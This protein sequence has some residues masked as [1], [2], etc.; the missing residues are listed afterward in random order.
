MN[1]RKF[2]QAAFSNLGALALGARLPFAGAGDQGRLQREYGAGQLDGLPAHAG[3]AREISLVAEPAQ[4]E[5][6]TRGVFEKWLY[7]GQF[8]GPEIRVKEG[9]RLRVTVKNSLPEATTVHW[10]GLPVQ[11][12]M[13]GVPDVTQPP[14]SPDDTFVYEFD[15]TPSGSYMYHSHFGLQPDRGLVGPLIVEEKKAHIDYDREYTLCLTDFLSGAP[16][17]LGS[18]MSGG[19]GMRST[20]VPPYIG[21]LINGRPPE[22]PA[23]F[24]VKTGERV[25][26]R[27]INPS[28]ATTYRFAIG[29]HPLTATHT[30]GRPVEP[31]RVEALYI[32]P[33]ERYDVLVD[34]RNPGAW[35]IAA[36]PDNDLPPARAVLR[37]TDSNESRPREGALPEGLT[38]GR[39]LQLGDLRGIGLPETRKPNRTF[40]LT[41]S[42]AMK[43][44]E[45]MISPEWTINGQAYP[46]AAPLDIH[47]GETVR[48][49]MVN[50]S[51]MPHP[52]HLHGHF[53]R[54]GN[55][56]KDTVIVWTHTGRVEFDF[57]A[58]NP[59]TWFFH[60]HNLYHM[61]AGMARLLRYQSTVQ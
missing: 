51:A 56:M 34:A 36:A 45:G 6:A 61:E 33:G 42:G 40:N 28:G 8:P 48:V 17:P 1:R 27:L 15:A 14:I 18:A 24:N 25:R 22:A 60:C 11:N 12:S 59:G 23:V 37:Y 55:V 54:A 13:D 7:N 4:F 44:S 38:G 3:T 16:K 46:N 5:V 39:M 50:E 10:H 19:G 30:D 26:L 52:M 32:G 2:I 49:R 43:K 53:F 29:G 20:Q 31:F 41:L 35:P 58:N 21:L 57:L 47:Q 9:E